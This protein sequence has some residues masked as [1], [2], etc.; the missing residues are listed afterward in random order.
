MKIRQGF[1][2]N[3]SS[4]SYLFLAKN[5]TDEEIT[6][7]ECIKTKENLEVF[8]DYINLTDEESIDFIDNS[9]QCNEVM[10]PPEGLKLL[11]YSDS[12]GFRIIEIEEFLSR[13]GLGLICISSER[14]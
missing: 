9:T 14:E 3:S 2:S 1:V 13:D 11:K 12:S 8:A 10:I 5:K 6:V 7:A 4:S